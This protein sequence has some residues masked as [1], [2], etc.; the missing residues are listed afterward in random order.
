M[1]CFLPYL[2][3][4]LK[5]ELCRIFNDDNIPTKLREKYLM[6]QHH[7]LKYAAASKDKV[8]NEVMDGM[9]AALS[10]EGCNREG[11]NEVFNHLQRSI[12]P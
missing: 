3:M 8:V 6:W 11:K 1:L 5:A 9:E 12:I 10:E 7:I 4:Q 2:S